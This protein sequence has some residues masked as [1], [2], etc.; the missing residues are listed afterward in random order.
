MVMRSPRS[1]RLALFA[2][3]FVLITTITC[4]PVW[5]QVVS[6]VSRTSVT[7]EDAFQLRVTTTSD[8]DGSL[9][10]TELQDDFFI[11]NQSMNQRHSSINGRV[12]RSTQWTLV[13]I[14]KRA[15]LLTIPEFQVGTDRTQAIAIQVSPS[16]TAEA[17]GPMHLS[18][19][20]EKTSPYIQEPIVVELH[21]RYQGRIRSGNFKFPDTKG[22]LLD[23]LEEASESQVTIQGQQYTQ[24]TQKLILIPQKSGALKIDP[25]VFRGT[26]INPRLQ[27]LPMIRRTQPIELNVR[28]IP[29]NYPKTAAW[30]PAKLVTAQDNLENGAT[31]NAQ[32]PFTR[33]I[34]VTA[35]GNIATAVPTLQSENH[36]Q[37]KQYPEPATEQTITK[38][39]TIIASK[40]LSVALIPLQGSQ[41]TL[42]AQTIHW[43]NTQRDQLESLTLPAKTVNIVGA[44]ASVASTPTAPIATPSPTMDYSPSATQPTQSRN[45]AQTNQSKSHSPTL[46]IAIGA[47]LLWLV[48]VGVWMALRSRKAK[49]SLEQADSRPIRLS[50]AEVKAAV[51]DAKTNV[52]HA[53]DRGDAKQTAEALIEWFNTRHPESRIHSISALVE[54]TDIESLQNELKHLESHLYRDTATQW[55]AKVIKKHFTKL[56]IQE[57]KNKQRSEL[58]PLYLDEASS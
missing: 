45:N 39:G 53:C 26:L 14:P 47:I 27:R 49:P 32:E 18:L 4:G 12:R 2:Y 8:F 58:E 51:D 30:L 13:L 9:D 24:W 21:L 36:T 33:T 20:L 15:G 50:A 41:A 48:T 10:T 16:G 7:V 52:Q 38:N 3:A 42:P 56:E 43:W 54:F 29:A 37:F 23:N 35:T 57:S 31:L 22:A 25:I 34:T 40:S 28:A 55:N 19:K 46:Y 5:A 11:D 17:Q 6:E 1:T 44:P